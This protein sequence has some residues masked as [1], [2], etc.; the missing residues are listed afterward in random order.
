MQHKQDQ[1]YD[2][3]D[4]N[5]CGGYMKCEKPEQPKNDQDCG[6]YPK[7]ILIS[8]FLRGPIEDRAPATERL[9]RAEPKYCH[10]VDTLNQIFGT[11]P[12]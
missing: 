2:Q 6:N 9:D 12:R 5:E 10:V 11:R 4:V 1:T 8:L 3:R 7:H